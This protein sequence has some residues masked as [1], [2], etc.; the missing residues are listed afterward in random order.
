MSAYKLRRELLDDP[1]GLGYAAMT[2]AEALASLTDDAARPAPDR[3][4]LLAS[5]IYEVIVRS[6][7][8]AKTDAEK[9]ELSLVLGLEGQIDVSSGSKAR[10]ALAAIFDAGSLTRTALLALVDNQ[11]Q[12]RAKELGI[13]STLLV[14]S[15]IASARVV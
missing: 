7:Y 1:L 8:L 12:S 14:E 15:T 10:A 3:E 5:E 9:S 2:D 11:T 13:Q 4:S 6:E